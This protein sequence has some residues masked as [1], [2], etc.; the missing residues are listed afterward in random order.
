M[1]SFIILKAVI[2]LPL[3]FFVPGY[4]TY[5][6]L[7]KEKLNLGFFEVVYPQI[8]ASILISGWI[9]LIL[10]ELGYFSLLNLL[11]LLIILSVFL[12]WKKKIKFTIKSYPKPKLNREPLLLIV[13]L[14]IAIGLFF[15]P[16]EWIKGGRDPGVYVN[17]GVNIAKTGSIIIHDPIME[18]MDDSTK[19]IFYQFK[20]N[21][22]VLKKIKFDGKQ[23]PGFYPKFD[24]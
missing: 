23:F 2:S 6:T 20:T 16:Y 18:G 14:L 7:V 17:T 8:L 3:I 11:F 13:I 21:P 22:E 5:N 19:K 12:L 15:H 9:G 24:S 1:E 4:I 10:A